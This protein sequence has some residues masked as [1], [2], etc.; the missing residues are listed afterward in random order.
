MLGQLIGE[1][2]IIRLLGEG[3]NGKVW[4]G[5]HPTLGNRGR[6]QNAADRAPRD[7]GAGSLRTRLGAPR[8]ETV[9][10]RNLEGLP[11]GFLCRPP[12]SSSP[13]SS[14]ARMLSQLVGRGSLD[15]DQAL[16]TS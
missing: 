1:Y 15:L 16:Q 11:R 7:P 6:H 9:P 8:C 13:S 5:E 12:R 10:P 14:T 4:L 2:R 3:P